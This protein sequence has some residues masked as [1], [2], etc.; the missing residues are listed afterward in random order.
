MNLSEPNPMLPVPHRITKVWRE[1]EDIFSMVLE[2]ANG[3]RPMR[4]APGQFNMLWQFGVG[5]VAISISGD[6]AGGDRLIHTVRAVGSVTREMQRLKKGAVIGVRGPFGTPW[7]VDQARGHDVVIVAG[8]LGL[9]P[10]RPAWLELLRNRDQYGRIILIYG[11]RT[12]KDLL[13]PDLLREWKAR[14]DAAV[15]VTVDAAPVSWRDNVGVVTTLIPRARFEPEATIAMVCGPEAMMRFVAIELRKRGV[16]SPNVYLSMERSMKCAI[17]FCGH[18]QFGP[19]F[20]CKD[21]PVLPYDRMER[22]FN[23]RE[24]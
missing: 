14:G 6:P 3:E 17:G 10:L 20:V 16:A 15:E 4:Y 5:E 19:H 9:A 1:T 13:Y 8:G 24:I 11:A 18:C 7:P 12:P 23:I 22:I 21:G 2:P